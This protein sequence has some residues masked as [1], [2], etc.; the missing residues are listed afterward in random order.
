MIQNHNIG[1]MHVQHLS[2]ST[3]SQGRCGRCRPGSG[4]MSD[5]FLFF[6]AP[7]ITLQTAAC[8][9]YLMTELHNNST[10]FTWH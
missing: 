10:R 5:L 8:H 7:S 2:G 6:N 9:H 1:M 3:C 4:V